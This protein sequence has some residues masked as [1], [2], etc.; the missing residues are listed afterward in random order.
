MLLSIGGLRFRNQHLEMNIDPKF[1]HRDFH[2]RRLNYGNMTHVNIS[3]SVT[4]DNKAV[5]FVALDRS[6]R[7]YYAC[8]AGC[9]DEPVL[10][11]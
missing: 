11:G 2:F 5:L 3:V 1:L 10:L 8:D 6:D 4:E 7:T 9:V